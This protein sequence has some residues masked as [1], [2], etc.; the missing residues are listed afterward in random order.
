MTEADATHWNPRYDG[1][2]PPPP[3][4]PEALTDA[5]T[6]LLATSGRALD[7]ACGAGAEAVWL[8]ER[9][10]CVTAL[11]VSPK[12]A[13]LALEASAAA[14]VGD[15]L[16][17]VVQDLDCGIPESM[18]DFDVIVCQRFRDT[19]LYGVLVERLKTGGI[20]VVTVLSETGVESPGA[21]H[22]P[23]GELA[24]A[25]DRTD[26]QVLHHHEAAGT[27]SIVIR[28]VA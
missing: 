7:V 9:G 3:A 13:A 11:D 22:A 26:C 1:R 25:F 10:L 23:S 19:E 15:R 16:D 20:A 27:E 5:V 12:A 6:D 8:A 17:V 2:T 24:E 18:D 4:R 28:R 14:G 21:F